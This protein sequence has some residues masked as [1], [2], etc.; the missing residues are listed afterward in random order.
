[1]LIILDGWGHSDIRENNALIEASTPNFDHLWSTCPHSTLD[2]SAHAVGL[3]EGQMGNSEV[4]HITIGAGTI[5]DTDLVRIAKAINTNEFET[6]PAFVQLFNHVKKYN[7]TLHIKG[8]LS[9]GG[10]HSHSAHLYAFLDAAK[11]SG[12]TRIAIHTFLDGRDTSPTSAS[13]YLSELEDVLDDMGIGHIASISGRFWAMDRDNNWDRVQ[14]VEQALFQGNS[15]KKIASLRPSE[16]MKKLYTEGAIDELLEPVIFLDSENNSYPISRNDGVFFFNFRADRARQLSTKIVEY[17]KEKNICFVTL[18]QYDPH[19]PSLVAFPPISIAKTLAD[20]ISDAG[21]TQAHIAETEKYAH[22]TYYLNGGRELPHTNE[23][24]ILIESRKDILTHN[25][26]PEMRAKEIADTA[27]SEIQKGTNFLA[28]NFANADMV[29]HTGDIQALKI[30]I[31]TVDHEL[32]RI[33]NSLKEKNGTAFITADHGNAETNINSKT[34]ERHTAHTTNPVPAILT[35][36]H[37]GTL[38]HGTLAD[39][40]PTILSFMGLTPHSSMKGKNLYRK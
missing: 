6:N 21:L 28:L 7:S 36:S 16:V 13:Q 30:A 14:K 27:I 5:I 1:M 3:P 37:G 4:G 32:G 26:A 18:T 23:R 8:L 12:I 2:A 39:I 31:E 35:T 20:I 17:S 19:I 38:K 29:G 15:P 22:I 34:G 9:P 11:R 10:V 33:I 24:H 40:T 25:L